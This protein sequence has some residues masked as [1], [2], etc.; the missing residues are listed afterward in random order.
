VPPSRRAMQV[1]MPELSKRMEVSLGEPSRAAASLRGRKRRPSRESGG[2]AHGVGFALEPLDAP[3][4]E[5]VVADLDGG[6]PFAAVVGEPG[7]GAVAD[8]G[9]RV[10]GAGGGEHEGAAG[11]VGEFGIAEVGDGV[12]DDG[13]CAPEGAVVGVEDAD[14]AVGGDVFGAFAEAAEPLA[15]V[16]DQVSEGGV[17]GAV[18]DALDGDEFGSRLF[19]RG[20][21]GEGEGGGEKRAAT[22]HGTVLP[23]QVGRREGRPPFHAD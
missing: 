18:P 8:V 15:V 7:E 16:L 22:E 14:A 21:G 19:G 20:E 5:V 10:H 6:G 23:I 3:E 4:P 12:V 2:V 17:G 1:A 13:P 9:G 11:V